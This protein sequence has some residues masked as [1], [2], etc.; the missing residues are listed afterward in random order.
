[1][2][3]EN[4]QISH[5]ISYSDYKKFQNILTDTVYPSKESINP[6]NFFLPTPEKVESFDPKIF[7]R[8]L[9]NLRAVVLPYFKIIDPNIEKFYR[10]EEYTKRDEVNN[11]ALWLLSAIDYCSNSKL[12]LGKEL[13]INQENNPRD[14]RLDVVAVRD[15]ETLVIET[16]TDTKTLL[17]E[18][19]FTFQINAYTSECLK[20]TQDYINSNKLLVLLVVGGEET[21]IYPT[22]HPDCVTG[23]VG[24]ISKIFYDKIIQNNIK[25]V[26]ANALWSIV[27]YKYITNKSI[28]IFK[29]L[30]AI[31]ADKES[32]GLLSGGLIKTKSKKLILEKINLNIF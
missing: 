14:G 9:F 8:S 7:L 4:Q 21:D 15:L 2:D 16:K 22:N 12:R 6:I 11:I 27:T 10:F 25:F 31:F 5:I 1:M 3:K 29:F 20:Y 30:D 18:N 24:N 28:D 26:S 23:T 17:S 13:E 32:I 19:R